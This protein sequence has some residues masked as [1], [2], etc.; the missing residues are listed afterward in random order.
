MGDASRLVVDAG[1]DG[2]GSKVKGQP[3]G[4]LAFSR[5][6]RA[7]LSGRQSVRE[8]VALVVGVETHLEALGERVVV[9]ADNMGE[10]ETLR[11]MRNGVLAP[12][13]AEALWMLV[14]SGR[15]LAGAEWV[16]SREMERRGVDGLSRQVDTGD[17]SLGTAAWARIQAWAPPLDVDRFASA[18]NRKCQ[19]FNARWAQPGVEAVDALRQFWGGVWNYACP[20]VVLVPKVV[21]L[22]LQQRVNTVLV[23]PEWKASWWWTA[24]VA[25]GARWLRLGKAE[26]VVEAGPSGRA[27]PIEKGWTLAAALLSFPEEGRQ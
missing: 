16:P 3:E 6:W 7:E 15:E 18:R 9:V 17:W 24:L 19:R 25:A 1:P 5:E 27:A 26:G 2:V 22:V 12:W 21:A 14:E 8:V 10:V 20:P 11:R 13:V 4:S 23:V